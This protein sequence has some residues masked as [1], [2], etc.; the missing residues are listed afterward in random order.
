MTSLVDKIKW[1]DSQQ[2][3]QYLALPSFITYRVDMTIYLK[4]LVRWLCGILR[5]NIR[6]LFI[7]IMMI[8]CLMEQCI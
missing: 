1:H 4:K 7:S 5:Y 6:P 2:I 8:D 3:Q